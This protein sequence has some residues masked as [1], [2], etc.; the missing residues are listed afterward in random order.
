MVRV[1]IERFPPAR[2]TFRSVLASES[3]WLQ[4]LLVLTVRWW[5]GTSKC[6]WGNNLRS[7]YH[8]LITPNFPFGCS[9]EIDGEFVKKQMIAHHFSHYY[10]QRCRRMVSEL[11]G[12]VGPSEYEGIWDGFTCTCKL[13]LGGDLEGGDSI[14]L[15]S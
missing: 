7:S 9:R 15:V 10:S 8:A 6:G 14:L 1:T 3:H 12:V 13:H 2:A 4:P 11:P 5:S